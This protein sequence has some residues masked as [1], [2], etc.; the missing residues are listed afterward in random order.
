MAYALVPVD[1]PYIHY[2][3]AC[4]VK[5]YHATVYIVYEIQKLIVLVDCITL[6]IVVC[7]SHDT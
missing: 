2:Y 4:F 1:T 7:R 6:V 3:L 5:C